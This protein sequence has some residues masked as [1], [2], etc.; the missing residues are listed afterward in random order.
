MEDFEVGNTEFIPFVPYG[1][2]GFSS[3]I[4]TIQSMEPDATVVKVGLSISRNSVAGARAD[5]KSWTDFLLAD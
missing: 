3:T 2:S 4:R 1:D 5:V